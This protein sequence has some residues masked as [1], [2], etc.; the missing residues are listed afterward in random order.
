MF[1]E[2][3]QKKCFETK[4]TPHFIYDSFIQ[5][6]SLYGARNATAS[7]AK[8]RIVFFDLIPDALPSS[9]SLALHFSPN[10]LRYQPS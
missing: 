7:Y 6:I 10:P 9:S 2:I 3:C 5:I 8:L 4:H 1:S